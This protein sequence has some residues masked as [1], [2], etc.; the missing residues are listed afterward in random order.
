MISDVYPKV[1]LAASHSNGCDRRVVRALNV[2]EVPVL[3]AADN[4]SVGV[5]VGNWKAQP[6]TAWHG[7]M[8]A[9]ARSRTCDLSAQ[10]MT[11][12]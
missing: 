7:R 4:G 12:A 5:S 9:T 11:L 6:K 1:I 3:L 10:E 2:I 8:C